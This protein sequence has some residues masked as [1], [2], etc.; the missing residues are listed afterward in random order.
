MALRLTSACPISQLSALFFRLAPTTFPH[1][2]IT[3]SSILTSPSP[4]S[5]L[6]LSLEFFQIVVEEAGR[7]GLVGTRKLEVADAL[8]TE[9]ETAVSYALETLQRWDGRGDEAEMLAAL[10][11]L[12]A[13]IGWG[14][15][16]EYVYSVTSLL[17]DMRSQADL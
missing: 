11:C 8:R 14:L 12:E 17:G 9:S 13:W 7:T 4:A 2:F 15:T 1:A 10:K 3:V 16:G 6:A 5:S